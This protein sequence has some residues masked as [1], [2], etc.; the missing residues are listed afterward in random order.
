M[1]NKPINITRLTRFGAAIGLTFKDGG[2]AEVRLMPLEIGRI[3]DC[4]LEAE[5]RKKK[6]DQETLAA[7]EVLQK[8]WRKFDGAIVVEAP[9]AMHKAKFLPVLDDR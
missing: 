5:S 7:L 2:A 6:P 4:W 1:P 8:K 9:I 3:L